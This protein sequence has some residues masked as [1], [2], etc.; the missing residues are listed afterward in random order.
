MI[1]PTGG[2][3]RRDALGLGYF[4]APR[5][6][7]ENGRVKRYRHRGNDYVCIPGQDVY[8]PFT[9]IP[10]RMKNPCD[11]YHGVLSRG[12]GIIG[13]LFYVAVRDDI[14]NVELKEGDVI[15]TAEDISTKFE[16]VIPHVHFQIDKIDPELLIG[17]Y[18]SLRGR[19]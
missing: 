4:G 1:N 5:E 10:I 11:G 17:I 3:I 14:L 16:G 18:R 8:I 7:I 15:G 9:A 2:N 6:K 13:T 12:R 19:I